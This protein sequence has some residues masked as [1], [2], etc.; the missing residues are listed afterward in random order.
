M[1]SNKILEQ[2]KAQVAEL[3]EAIKNSAGGVL[4]N[5]Q[6]ITVEDDTKMRKELREAGVKYVVVKNTMT[7]R[8]CEMNGMDDMK[9]YLN[10]MTALAIG[11]QD[12]IA[13]AKVLKKYA[14]KLETFSILAGY[15]D[16]A[17]IDEKTVNALADIPSKETLI[18]KFLG[19]IRS[20]LY[21]LAYA[22]QAVVDKGDS[23]SAEEAAPAEEAPAAEEAAPATEEAAPAEA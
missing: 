11:A 23:A 17:V 16:G 15:L 21:G 1:P 12:P 6:G 13:P 2:K 20:P 9:P 19:S 3:A 14:D 10:G 8:A 5:Y 18:A 7:G 22:L 4:V